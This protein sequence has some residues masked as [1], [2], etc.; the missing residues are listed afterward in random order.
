MNPEVFRQAIRAGGERV[1]LIKAMPCT[2]YNPQ[3]NYDEQRGCGRCQ[4]G[5]LYEEQTLADDVRVL[6]TAVKKRYVHPEFGFVKV[7]DLTCQNMPDEILLGPLDKLVLVGRQMLQRQQV[8]KGVDTLSWPYP[9]T[10]RAVRDRDVKYTVDTDCE[11]D[12][13]NKQIVWLEGG[14]APGDGDTYTVEYLYNPVFWYLLGDESPP[15]PVPFN[16]TFAPQKGYLVAKHP[17]SG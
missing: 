14:D 1:R 10:L 11:L 7:G 16:T 13:P 6:I 15:R 2:C 4:F 3:E 9:C 8:Q 12:A 5:Q 17:G